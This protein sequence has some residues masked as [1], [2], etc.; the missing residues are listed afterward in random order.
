MRR[1]ITTTAFLLLLPFPSIAQF[2]I[3]E[4]PT[5]ANETA[6]L[7]S[8]NFDFSDVEFFS[9]VP[10]D[11]AIRVLEAQFGPTKDAVLKAQ[12]ACTLIR[13]GDKDNIYWNFLATKASEV[14]Q[15]PPPFPGPDS[16]GKYSPDAFNSAAIAWAKK[17]GISA[18]QAMEQ[19]LYSQPGFVL[20]LAV[21]EDRRAIPLL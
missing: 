16:Q 20:T 17:H 12:I 15:D 1:A 6:K 2:T 5:L 9:H 14:M 11:Q 8:G 4:P 21:T 10:P 3:P 18:D 7:K 13:Q 19:V